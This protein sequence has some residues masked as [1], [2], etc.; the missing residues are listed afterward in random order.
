MPYLLPDKINRNAN[1]R[2]RLV[3][4]KD[5]KWVAV[6][7]GALLTLTRPENWEEGTGDL[8]VSQAVNVAT[9]II[10]EVTFNSNCD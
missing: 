6:I 1:C 4:P 7:M 9:Q 3:I 10:D 5:P 8:S 2:L